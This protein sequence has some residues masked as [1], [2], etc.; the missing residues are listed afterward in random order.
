M[1]LFAVQALFNGLAWA[2]WVCTYFM[3]ALFNSMLMENQA[4]I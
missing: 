3:N 1:I 2:P 4:N